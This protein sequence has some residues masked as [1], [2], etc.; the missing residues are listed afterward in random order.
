MSCR[1]IN[2][3]FTQI[4]SQTQTHDFCLTWDI[5]DLVCHQPKSYSTYV[6][7]YLSWDL[8]CFSVAK[9]VIFT[10]FHSITFTKACKCVQIW[11]KY[12]P[13]T[14]FFQIIKEKLSFTNNL[15]SGLQNLILDL[16]LKLKTTYLLEIFS[17]IDFI[18]LVGHF[19]LFDNENWNVNTHF[20]TNR[21]KIY[22]WNLPL[23]QKIEKGYVCRRI[24]ERLS[25]V[26]TEPGVRGF[27]ERA[28]NFQNLGLCTCILIDTY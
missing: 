13:L 10:N 20:V 9:S 6:R 14:I 19:T 21:Y 28:F 12:T 1:A 24:N 22:Q 23:Q 17:N 2:L 7:F 11:Y 4:K 8:R 26:K 27:I 5:S 16:R 15:H 3:R 25:H 18:R